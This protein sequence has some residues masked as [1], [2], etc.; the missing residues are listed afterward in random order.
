MGLTSGDIFGF[1]PRS[2]KVLS[3]DHMIVY[4]RIFPLEE[5]GV[6]P[7]Y[8]LGENRALQRIFQDPTRAL[9]I[10][11]YRPGDS[12]KHIHWKASARH[13][14]LNVKVFE[15]TTNLKVSLLLAVDSFQGKGPQREDTFELAVS[16]AASIAYYLIENG[17]P[18]GLFTNTCLADSGMPAGIPPGGSRDQLIHIL[19]A[20][21]KVTLRWNEPFETFLQ[22][23]RENLPPGST[24]IVI[25]AQDPESLPW[26]MKDLKESGY[27][28]LLL[29]VGS[30]GGN[31]P[32]GMIPVHRI[33][34]PGSL[35]GI[36]SGVSP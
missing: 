7:V 17:T 26:W 9:G 4:P 23:E 11:D 35:R 10:R 21:A 6:P 19:E 33:C 12:L 5:L 13:S 1:Y 32:E 8:P 20:L 25:T 24:L 18:A 2:A 27:Q 30:E 15:F 31:G 22:R 14:R 28:L 34:N 16:T 3:E 36:H 29:A